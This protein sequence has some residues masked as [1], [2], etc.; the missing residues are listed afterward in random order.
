[1]PVL[2]A[3]GQQVGTVKEVRAGDFLLDR[4]MRRDIYVPF[5]FI[6]DATGDRL[7]LRIRSEEIDQRGWESPPL[8]Q[9]A[10]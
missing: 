9:A 10:A 5:D 6:R 4:P 3:D 7:T 2:D 8:T 1:M